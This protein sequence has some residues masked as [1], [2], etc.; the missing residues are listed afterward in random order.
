MRNLLSDVKPALLTSIDE[1]FSKIVDEAPLDAPKRQVRGCDNEGAAE[2]GLG[3]GEIVSLTA[4]IAAHLKTIGDANWKERQAAIIAIDDIV[5]KAKPIGCKGPYM[6]G[7]CGE[8]W[9]SLKARL[10]DSNKNLA[11]LVLGLLAKIADA[12]GPS[13]DKQL[14]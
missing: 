5:S 4:P 2:E 3:G 14:N 10:K 12:V 11:I 9:A 13:V 8:L 6:D 1:A 7:A